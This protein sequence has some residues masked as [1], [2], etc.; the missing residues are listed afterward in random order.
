MVA[1]TVNPGTKEAGADQALDSSAITVGLRK[2]PFETETHDLLGLEI[3]DGCEL[4]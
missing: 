3:I 4:P 2:L 1:H